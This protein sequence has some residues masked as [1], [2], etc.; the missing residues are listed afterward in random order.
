[1][2]F[3][4]IPYDCRDARDDYSAQRKKQQRMKDKIFVHG[5][6][7]EMTEFDDLSPED[8]VD[9]DPDNIDDAP[10]GKTA[11]NRAKYREEVDS[12]VRN[13]GWLDDSQDGLPDMGNLNPINPN[14]VQSGKEWEK[15]IQEKKTQ[16]QEEKSQNAPMTIKRDLENNVVEPNFSA[17]RW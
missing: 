10:L 8:L 16:V 9:Y 6:D 12:I 7:N 15:T 3:F 17:S 13:A 4:N 2:K 11:L 1:M 5:I 14:I